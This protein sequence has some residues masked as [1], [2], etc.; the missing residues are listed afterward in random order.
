M[1]GAAEI[2]DE[3]RPQGLGMQLACFAA[4]SVSTQ[5]LLWRLGKGMAGGIGKVQIGQWMLKRIS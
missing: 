4:K 5:K 1:S 3:K 2:S